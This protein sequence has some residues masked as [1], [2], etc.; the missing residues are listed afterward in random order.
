MQCS[1]GGCSLAQWKDIRTP[2][3]QSSGLRESLCV[4]KKRRSCDGRGGAQRPV[5]H[6]NE[7]KKDGCAQRPG[8]HAR[9][10]PTSFH[11]FWLVLVNNIQK[12]MAETTSK[13]ADLA[14]LRYTSFFGLFLLAGSSFLYF[15]VLFT[16]SKFSCWEFWDPPS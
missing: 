12:H 11:I 3:C 2:D 7:Y 5:L 9:P 14:Y 1:S 6:V 10:K 15:T 4:K 13:R 8:A 16:Y